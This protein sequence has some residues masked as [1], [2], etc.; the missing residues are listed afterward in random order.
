M[1]TLSSLPLEVQQLIA[2]QALTLGRPAEPVTVLERNDDR[3]ISTL[4]TLNSDWHRICKP[5]LWQV[6]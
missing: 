5:I 4:A 6:S 1:A 2:R 3:C